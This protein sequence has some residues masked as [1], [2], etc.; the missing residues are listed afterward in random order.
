M[1]I[2][3]SCATV[4][5]RHN[6]FKPPIVLRSLYVTAAAI[7]FTTRFNLLQHHFDRN[8]TAKCRLVLI[9]HKLQWPCSGRKCVL[10]NATLI[11]GPQPFPT[12]WSKSFESG[13]N[14]VPLHPQSSFNRVIISSIFS[15]IQGGCHHFLSPPERTDVTL[16]GRG[17]IIHAQFDD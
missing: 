8:H 15:H 14:C 17:L 16:R 2:W 9:C 7:L 4:L 11:R 12:V 5:T 6:F 10:C 1:F 13:I 3:R